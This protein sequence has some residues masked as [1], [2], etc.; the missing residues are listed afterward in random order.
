MV[1]GIRL[2]RIRVESLSQDE[3]PLGQL[4]YV[5]N[6]R[7]CGPVRSIFVVSLEPVLAAYQAI[8]RGDE[9]QQE[10]DWTRA[11]VVALGRANGGHS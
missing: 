11:D 5:W 7:S 2:L 8:R 1:R 10:R 9:P 3:R 4:I 6:R